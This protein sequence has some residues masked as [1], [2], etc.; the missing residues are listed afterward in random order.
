MYRGEDPPPPQFYV[1]AVLTTREQYDVHMARGLMEQADYT[2][3]LLKAGH[4]Q[5]WETLRRRYQFPVG[6]QYDAT[7]GTVF[8][9]SRPRAVPNSPDESDHT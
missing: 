5:V 2:L 9:E 8:A 4:A 1:V 7:T 3:R 6:Y